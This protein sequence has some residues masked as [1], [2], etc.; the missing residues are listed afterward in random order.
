MAQ[1]QRKPHTRADVDAAVQ[2]AMQRVGTW[3]AQQFTAEISAV[4][5]GYP[6]PPQVRDIVDTGRLRASQTATSTPDGVKFSWPTEYAMQ[7]HEGGTDLN[8]RA[9]PGRPW[10]EEPLKKLPEQF[11]KIVAE[12]LNKRDAQ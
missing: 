11:G 5:W 12:E 3:L 6:T 9:F 7:V 8:G 2:A 4:K 1:P 10:T